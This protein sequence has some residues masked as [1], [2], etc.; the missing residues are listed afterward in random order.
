MGLCVACNNE[1]DVVGDESNLSDST[2]SNVIKFQPE[3]QF[4]A[5]ME[6][7]GGYFFFPYTFHRPGFF[8]LIYS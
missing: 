6:D 3:H 4:D 8:T 1:S 5:Y 7:V 2:Q